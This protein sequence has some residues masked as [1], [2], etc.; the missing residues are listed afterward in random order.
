[1]LRNLR[2]RGLKPW[3]CTIADGHLGIWAALA[4]LQPTA[5]EPRCWNQVSGVE[6][7]QA[8]TRRLAQSRM[9]T[10][11]TQPQRIGMNIGDIDRSDVMRTTAREIV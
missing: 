7:R 5:A 8:S 6:S 9:A 1:M 4:A 3:H 10:S 11:Y 2:M